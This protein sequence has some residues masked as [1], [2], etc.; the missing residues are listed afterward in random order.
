MYYIPECTGTYLGQLLK[1][2]VN[3][4][5][6][7]VLVP[8]IGLLSHLLGLCLS[9]SLDSERLGFSLQA[10]SLSTGLCLDNSLVPGES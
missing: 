3:H 2:H 6:I 9:L 5:S 4:S 7:L 10:D 1:D 8:S